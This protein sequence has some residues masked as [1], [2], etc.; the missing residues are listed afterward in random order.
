MHGDNGQV[1]AVE[2]CLLGNPAD[3]IVQALD[4]LDGSR[5][6]KLNLDSVGLTQDLGTSFLREF[7]YGKPFSVLARDGWFNAMVSNRLLSRYVSK[8]CREPFYCLD[9]GG[10]NNELITGKIKP[11]WD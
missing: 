10:S 8:R 7:V 1:V 2:P 11:K 5:A 9:V 6:V 3:S 4:L